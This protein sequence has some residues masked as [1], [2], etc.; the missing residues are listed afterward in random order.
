VRQAE[1]IARLVDAKEMTPNDAML[2]PEYFFAYEEE[3]KFVCDYF[4]QHRCYPNIA[5][6]RTQ[7][8]EF[9]WQDIG[10]T[11]QWLADEVA[12]EFLS[13]KVSKALIE[14]NDA[15]E[16]NPREAAKLAI[17]ELQKL[18]TYTDVLTGEVIDLPKDWQSRVAESERRRQ[19]TER[20]TSGIT[21]G[22]DMIDEVTS[23]TQPGEI[24]II[25]ART[26]EG[27]SLFLL[28]S[29]YKAVMQG[30]RVAFV[31]PEMNGYETGVRLD[32][33]MYGV[34]SFKLQAGK[35]YDDEWRSYV[36]SVSQYEAV[37]DR[38][39]LLFYETMNLG[40][41]FTT[42]DLST[43][44]QREKPDLLCLDGVMLIEPLKQDK[45]PRK[46]LLNTMDEIKAIVT[47]TG[48][49]MRIAHQANRESAVPTGRRAKSLA[50]SDMLPE[51]HHM[52]E[53][54]AVE[55]YATRAFSLKYHTGRMY[56]AVRKNRNGPKGRIM[57]MSYDIDRSIMSDMRVE[58]ADAEITL[59]GGGNEPPT[60]QMQLSA[61][62]R[63][64]TPF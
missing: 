51:L 39:S 4:R 26:S 32:S 12:Q 42:A 41:R 44:I 20:S 30:F 11:A 7:F 5:T 29:A 36:D 28:Y 33:M 9:P 18:S 25:F 10:E 52:A 43:V 22:F 62:S 58:D 55:Q 50:L 40:R 38:S 3:W 59:G 16:I 15:N 17:V 63:D 64:E 49:P 45:D 57:S 1:L 27:K 61:P 54:G 8:V 37:S 13:G 34:S 24:E 6:F 2:R 14:I 23:G 46:R 60:Q 56:V 48:C 47:I 21:F 35:L 53:S 19:H 31:S